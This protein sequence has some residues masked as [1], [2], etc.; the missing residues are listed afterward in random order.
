MHL[1]SEV[2]E[3]TRLR[4]FI[5][6]FE[7]NTNASIGASIVLPSSWTK[8]STHLAIETLQLYAGHFETYSGQYAALPNLSH[9]FCLRTPI[10]SNFELNPPISGPA[11][12]G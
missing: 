12:N 5:D 7:G 9:S 11:H 4:L 10:A 1:D 8:S 3:S 2:D 6:N